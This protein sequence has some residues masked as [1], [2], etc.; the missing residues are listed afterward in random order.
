[1]QRLT[2]F[3]SHFTSTA[4]Q[5]TPEKLPDM[6]WKGPDGWLL[7]GLEAGPVHRL[8]GPFPLAGGWWRGDDENDHA[9]LREYHFAETRGGELCWVYHEPASG[10]WHRTGVFA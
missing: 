4:Q 5:F 10:R 8:H 2:E 1:M 3:L 7:C 6:P 9:F